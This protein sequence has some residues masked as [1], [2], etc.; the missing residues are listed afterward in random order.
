[1]ISMT[2]PKQYV[3]VPRDAVIAWQHRSWD[4]MVAAAEAG[5]D[6]LSL[7]AEPKKQV[8]DLK[9]TAPGATKAVDDYPFRV[10]GQMVFRQGQARWDGAAR[11]NTAMLHTQGW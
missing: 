5:V 9:S 4:E 7:A 2:I 11:V 3:C 10:Q 6:G 1:M 8:P